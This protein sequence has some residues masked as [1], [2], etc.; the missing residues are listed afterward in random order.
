[1]A[2]LTLWHEPRPVPPPPPRGRRD[3]VLVGVLLALTALE[4]LVRADLP[5]R[6]VAV[7]VTAGL[8]PT[9]LWRRQRPLLMLAIAFGVAAVVPFFTHGVVP[10]TYTTA[11]FVLLPFSLYRWGSGREMVLGTA[12]V[13]GQL[14]LSVLVGQ[15]GLTETVQGAAVLAVV[16]AVAVALRYR[17]RARSREL[18]RVRWLEREKLARDLHDTVAHHVSA[19]A[20]RAQAGL[21]TAASRPEA[22]A[23][24][25][26]LIEA[27]ASQ[28]LA[29]MRTMVRVLRDDAPADYEPGPVAEDLRRLAAREG[30]GV[31]VNVDIDGDLALVPAPIGTAL[32]RL[33]RESVTNSHRH[34]KQATRVEVR[35]SIDDSVVRLRVNDDGRPNQGGA[36]GY[37]MIGMRERVHL[38]G[39]SMLAGPDPSGGW[40]VAVELPLAGPGA[41]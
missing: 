13:I 25:L 31:P 11:F 4:G 7:A 2:S 26:R 29:E 39:G 38:L 19:M 15:T 18:D 17:A 41:A 32:Y 37:G 30:A 10:Q 5:V 27:E 23:E 33:A 20:I 34:A 35:V 22:A 16:A 24:A 6:P 3:Y 12:V 14:G 28:A 40:T 9:L 1:M 8:I 36:S 21:A